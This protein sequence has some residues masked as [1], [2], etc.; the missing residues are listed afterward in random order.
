MARTDAVF[1]NFSTAKLK[2]NVVTGATATTQITLTGIATDDHLLFV[3]H[4]TDDAAPAD[5]TAETTI[6]AAG[7]IVLSTTDTSDDEL[8]VVWVD[9]DA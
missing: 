5:R 4:H 8:L 6:P 2:F 9:V 3:Y 7:K 1:D